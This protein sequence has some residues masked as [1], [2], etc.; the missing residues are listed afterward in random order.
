M[1]LEIFA[2][3]AL[4]SLLR[5]QPGSAPTAFLEP[6]SQCA[7]Y[8][9]E[10]AG[11]AEDPVFVSNGACTHP[12]LSPETLA[13]DANDNFRPAQAEYA[14]GLHPPPRPLRCARAPVPA[15]KSC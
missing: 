7:R 3:Q 9:R 15:W 12:A 13:Q 1:V 2:E 6:R 10:F 11:L 8:L 5:E 14:P 4:T